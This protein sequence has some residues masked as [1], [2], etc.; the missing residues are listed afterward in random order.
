MT[1]AIVYASI[2]GGFWAARSRWGIE[3]SGEHWYPMEHPFRIHVVNRSQ[4]PVLVDAIDEKG[5]RWS[6]FL[7]DRERDYIDVSA[8]VGSQVPISVRPLSAF[9][10]GSRPG[11]I[12]WEPVAGVDLH[13]VVDES[14]QAV[15][16]LKPATRTDY[17]MI[18][19]RSDHELPIRVGYDLAPGNG[20]IYMP[21]ARDREDNC[22]VGTGVSSF[23]GGKGF[24]VGRPASLAYSIPAVRNNA[25]EA[26]AVVDEDGEIEV[27]IGRDGRVDV[28][29]MTLW[30]SVLKALQL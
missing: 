4:T 22:W 6:V 16:T 9:G 5:H 8:P 3:G 30:P 12:E 2:M 7:I 20:G 28:H 18:S 24:A 21:D 26:A 25:C 15:R 10:P 19:V 14:G 13:V 23:T 1:F 11:L 17:S 27:A 29:P